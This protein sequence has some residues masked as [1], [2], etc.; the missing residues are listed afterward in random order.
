VHPVGFDRAFVSSPGGRFDMV[1][2]K[3]LII[4]SGTVVVIDQLSKQ[5]ILRFFPQ[6]E[7]VEVIPGFFSLTHVR[8]TGGAFG[9]FAGEATWI[10]TA[11]FLVV[12]CV[13]VGIL[14]HLYRTVAR[15]SKWIGAG[16]ALILAGAIGNLIDRFRFGEVVDFLDFYFGTYHWPAFNVADS[17]ICGGVGI[18]LINMALRRL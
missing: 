13:A 5:L 3:L 16:F 4:L 9:L 17:A 15:D 18:L 6:N 14:W 10:R 2:H 7:S 1:R 12:S 8:N 11:A